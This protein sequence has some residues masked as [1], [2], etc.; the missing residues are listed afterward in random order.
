MP[1][2]DVGLYLFME[3]I[4]TI[5]EQTTSCLMRIPCTNQ[6]MRLYDNNYYIL[7]S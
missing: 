2:N 3:Y 5:Q 1:S 6:K 7:N 4:I